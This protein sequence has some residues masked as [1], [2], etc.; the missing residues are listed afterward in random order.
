MGATPRYGFGTI[1]RV[2]P[3]TGDRMIVSDD[4]TG[5]GPGLSHSIDL[6]VE[7]DSSIVALDLWRP[8][9]RIE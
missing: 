3:V 4:T 6:V 7:A 8:H 2:D 1:F 9:N 5:S